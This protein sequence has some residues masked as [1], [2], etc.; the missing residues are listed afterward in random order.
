[1]EFAEYIVQ[2]VHG[3]HLA[4]AGVMIESVRLA[5]A[6]GIVVAHPARWAANKDCITEYDPWFLGVCQESSPEYA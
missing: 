4:N 2:G 6:C 3:Q 5:I 1:M